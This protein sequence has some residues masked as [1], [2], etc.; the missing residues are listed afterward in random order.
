MTV[1]QL[2]DGHER[3]WKQV[4]GWKSI[5]RRLWTARNFSLIA[6]SANMGYRFYAHNLHRFYNCD[7]Q[8][9]PLFPNPF[10]SGAVTSD[11]ES[12][13]EKSRIVCG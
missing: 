4:Y 7:W 13:A 9:D 5:A 10:A 8:V 12:R 3:A 6:L 1:Q 11:I 2:A